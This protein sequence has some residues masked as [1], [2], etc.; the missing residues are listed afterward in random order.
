MIMSP[1]ALWPF[2]LDYPHQLVPLEGEARN[3]QSLRTTLLYK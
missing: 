1:S 2:I 3:R